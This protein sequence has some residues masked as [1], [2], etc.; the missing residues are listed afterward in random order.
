MSWNPPP[1]GSSN[2]DNMPASAFL[3]S[4]HKKYPYKIKR[5]GKWQISK[6]GLRAAITRAAQQHDSSIEKKARR[7][8]LRLK[9]NRKK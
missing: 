3:D 7:I 1:A 6:S 2:R 9:N 4:R 8:Y 5:N